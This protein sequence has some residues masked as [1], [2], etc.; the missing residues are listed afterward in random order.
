MFPGQ[1]TDNAIWQKVVALR[2]E[3]HPVALRTTLA[4]TKM[5]LEELLRLISEG[6]SPPLPGDPLTRIRQNCRRK[7]QGLVHHR[8]VH[9][10]IPKP[11]S[12]GGPL[13]FG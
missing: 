6:L 1:R 11:L 7:S 8:R 10:E 3:G 4:W 13:G 12:R 2:E 9:V 5:E